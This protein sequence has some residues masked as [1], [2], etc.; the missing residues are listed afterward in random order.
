MKYPKYR[1]NSLIVFSIFGLLSACSHS[2]SSESSPAQTMCAHS[3]SL[4][5]G[6]V[7]GKKVD[8]SSPLAHSLVLLLMKTSDGTINCT[9][10]LV[11]QDVV[12]TA[13]H[14]V[15][16]VL[17][18][19]SHLMKII[20]STEPQC[21]A[22]RGQNLSQGSVEA[23]RVPLNWFK[24]NHELSDLALVKLTAAAPA[25]Y[26]PLPLAKNFPEISVHQAVTVAGYGKTTKDYDAIDPQP[27]AL[28]VTQVYSL[29]ASLKEILL[30]SLR[31]RDPNSTLNAEDIR[32]TDD[33]E[34]LFFD[35]SEGHGICAGDSG[36]PALIESGNQMQIIG[37]ASAVENPLDSTSKCSLL[38]VHTNVVHY[39]SWLN[40]TL[41]DLD[42]P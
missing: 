5:A 28:R 4:T 38:G 8:A 40:E 14:C 3:T 42:Q 36:A 2:S 10:T 24:S 25:E 34:N 22:H 6:I 16:G 15:A 39:Q 13:A 31:K 9:G 32:N 21:A 11:S 35:Q 17:K 33:K 27:L 1:L 41:Q 7:G 18:D 23:V 37:V 29:N 30:Q 20:F 12:L 26:S 19:P